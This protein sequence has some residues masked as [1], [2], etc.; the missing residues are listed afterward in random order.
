MILPL[1][2]PHPLPPPPHT[3]TP[4]RYRDSKFARNPKFEL[5]FYSCEQKR[6]G[7]AEGAWEESDLSPPPLSE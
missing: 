6:G 4:A 3:H 1:P 5:H 7:G 2:P